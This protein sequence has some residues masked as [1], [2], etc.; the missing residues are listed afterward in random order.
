[1][2]IHHTILST[3]IQQWPPMLRNLSNSIIFGILHWYGAKRGLE[4]T[5][6]IPELIQ[7]F[8]AESTGGESP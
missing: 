4:K 5:D 6:R 1:M 8:D 2:A 7:R 3:T